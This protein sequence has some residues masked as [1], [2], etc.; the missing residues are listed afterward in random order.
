[1][2]SFMVMPFFVTAISFLVYIYANPNNFLTP[3]RAFVTLALFNMLQA[4]M[5][6]LPMALSFMTSVCAVD[7]IKYCKI[8]YRKRLYYLFLIIIYV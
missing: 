1:M 3:E 7:F 4:P 2:A 6:M 5:G 8:D